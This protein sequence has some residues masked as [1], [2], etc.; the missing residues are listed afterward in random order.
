MQFCIYIFVFLI[1][2]NFSH[3][4]QQKYLSIAGFEKIHILLLV[5]FSMYMYAYRCNHGNEASDITTKI[6]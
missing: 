1:M 2:S 4:L 6:K 3:Y 5:C